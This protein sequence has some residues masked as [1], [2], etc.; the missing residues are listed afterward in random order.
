MSKIIAISNQKGGVG[1]TTT[2]ISLAGALTKFNKKILLID[3][4]P[5]GNCGRG[6]GI[7]ITITKLTIEDV[8]MEKCSINDAIIHTSTNN[9]DIIISN[10]KLAGIESDIQ[11]KHRPFYVLKNALKGLNYQYDFII[12]DCPPSLGILNLNAL[13]SADSVLIPVQCEYYALEGVAQIL[14]SISKVQQDYNPDLE[15]QGFLLTMYDSRLR[16]ATEV[17]QEIR[18]LFK[19]KTFVTQIPRNSSLIEAAAEG[20]PVTS[21]RPTAAGS[22][23]YLSLAREILAN[24]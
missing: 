16:L 1:K 2:A 6:M 20:K 3:L 10:L 4:D 19:E 13:C 17:T 21:F 24:E 7:D 9:V 18:G 22:Q 12:I 5:Q 11:R 14:S 8:L 23:A 15:I